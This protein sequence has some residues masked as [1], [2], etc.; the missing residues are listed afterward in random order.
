[1][2]SSLALEGVGDVRPIC[3]RRRSHSEE[4]LKGGLGL[5]RVVVPKRPEAVKTEK[6][7]PIGKS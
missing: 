1:M 3:Q 7:I 5:L 6:K 2:L 4:R